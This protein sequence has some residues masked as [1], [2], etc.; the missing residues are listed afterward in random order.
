VKHGLSDPVW[1]Q[2]CWNDG[3]KLALDDTGMH[4]LPERPVWTVQQLRDP[5]F[6]P[7]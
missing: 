5:E 7:D 6:F 1:L 4:D 2:R 3:L